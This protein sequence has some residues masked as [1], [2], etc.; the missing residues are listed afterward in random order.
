MLK[1]FLGILILLQTS[2]ATPVTSDNWM[3]CRVLCQKD[4]GVKEA[5]IEMRGNLGCHCNNDVIYWPN[6]NSLFPDLGY[7]KQIPEKAIGGGESP[8]PTQILKPPLLDA[9]KLKARLP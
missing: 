4:G 5:C 8:R 3:M 9:K 2:C 1:N 7:Q 6:S